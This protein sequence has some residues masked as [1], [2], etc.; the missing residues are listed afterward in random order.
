MVFFYFLL[1]LVVYGYAGL[2]LGLNL[3]EV[4]DS[5]GKQ[6]GIYLAN[7]RWGI[8]MYRMVFGYGSCFG[9]ASLAIGLF[10]SANLVLVTHMALSWYMRS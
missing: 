7:G 8:A 2:R 10:L 1:Y 3:D 9:I 5:D 4:I 6:V